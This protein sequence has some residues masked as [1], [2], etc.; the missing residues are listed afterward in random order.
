MSVYNLQSTLKNE[1]Y[2]LENLNIEIERLEV[3]KQTIP[4]ISKNEYEE[5]IR[6]KAVLNTKLQHNIELNT[7]KKELEKEHHHL[8]SIMDTVHAKPLQS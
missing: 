5:T 8:L 1:Q 4:M 2:T 6:K 3:Q 7:K